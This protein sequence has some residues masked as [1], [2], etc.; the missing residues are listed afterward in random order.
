MVFKKSLRIFEKG[1]LTPLKLL[2]VSPF[3]DLIFIQIFVEFLF[4]WFETALHD[5]LHLI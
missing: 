5:L 2:L 4:L 3:L 1:S